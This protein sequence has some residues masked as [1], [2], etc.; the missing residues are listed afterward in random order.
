MLPQIKENILGNLSFE[1]QPSLTYQMRLEENRVLGECDDLK[2]MEQAVYKILNTQRYQYPIYSWNYGIELKDLFG[3][4]VSY[5]IPEIERR[6]TEA[7][8][9]DERVKRVHD[10]EFEMK[11]RGRLFV[12]F[13][14]DTTKGTVAAEKEVRI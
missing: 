14:A 8:L 6:I 9:Q 2:A 10:F 5:C 3:Q 11:G 1:E 12:S 4:P 7:L 13:Q